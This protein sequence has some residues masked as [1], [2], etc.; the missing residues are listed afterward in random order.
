LIRLWTIPAPSTTQ[1]LL[2]QQNNAEQFYLGAIVMYS[3]TAP[4]FNKIKIGGQHHVDMLP[5]DIE[6]HTNIS[7]SAEITGTNSFQ[8]LGTV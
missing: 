4:I 6:F 1:I 3:L 2:K 5:A 8:P 7:Q